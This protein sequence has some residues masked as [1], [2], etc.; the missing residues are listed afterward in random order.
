MKRIPAIIALFLA[1]PLIAVAQ[2]NNTVSCQH[3]PCTV[4]SPAPARSRIFQSTDNIAI[5]GLTTLSMA[6]AHGCN[7]LAQW[8]AEKKVCAIH[9]T[10]SSDMTPPIT[11]SPVTKDGDHQ[12]MIC[13]YKPAP[14]KTPE[15]TKGT[16]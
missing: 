8:D 3:L 10:F 7:Y 13:W 5:A 1:V 9:V 6:D 15:P 2:T 4:T 12:A 11:C 14:A 16:K